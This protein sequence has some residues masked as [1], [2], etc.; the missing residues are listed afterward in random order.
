MGRGSRG[1]VL[2]PPVPA[3]PM[4]SLIQ[5]LTVLVDELHCC[6]FLLCFCF[7]F[8]RERTVDSG[9]L[10]VCVHSTCFFLCWNIIYL[11]IYLKCSFQRIESYDLRP[12]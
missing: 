10:A 2:Q 11:I 3:H 8:F 9:L 5:L 12:K 1:L 4:M 7:C 6:S